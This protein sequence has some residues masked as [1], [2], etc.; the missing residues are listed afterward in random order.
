MTLWYIDQQITT[1]IKIWLKHT[2]KDLAV[3]NDLELMK[4]RDEFHV[5]NFWLCKFHVHHLIFHS[6]LHPFPSI[7]LTTMPHAIFHSN[8]LHNQANPTK[9]ASTPGTPYNLVGWPSTMP[10]NYTLP[11]TRST[12]LKSRWIILSLQGSETLPTLWMISYRSTHWET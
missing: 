12:F 7:H 3:V 6:I 4:C 2:W 8:S 9:V 1:F 5:H 10:Y 11:C